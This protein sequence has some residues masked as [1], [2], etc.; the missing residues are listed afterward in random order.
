MGNGQPLFTLWD[1]NGGRR[2]NANLKCL[3]LDVQDK[4][5]DETAIFLHAGIPFETIGP[6]PEHKRLVR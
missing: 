5:N 3:S 4:G 2:I 6:D 1:L